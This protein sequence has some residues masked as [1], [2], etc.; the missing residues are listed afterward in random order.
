MK[1]V[2][3]VYIVEPSENNSCCH[4]RYILALQFFSPLIEDAFLICSFHYLFVPQEIH[5]LLRQGVAVDKISSQLT[6]W[7]SALFEFLPPFI[8]RQ[9]NS[10]IK[11]NTGWSRVNLVLKSMAENL[12]MI[13]NAAVTP[14]P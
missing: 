12:T 7:A 4:C 5:G 11:L 13:F 1:F 3:Q 9:V 8:R 14:L 6:P 2:N 10:F